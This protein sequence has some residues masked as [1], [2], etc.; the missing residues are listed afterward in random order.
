[1]SGYILG[2][3]SMGASPKICVLSGKFNSAIGEKSILIVHRGKK[4]RS[5][6]ASRVLDW[7]AAL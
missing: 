3:L 1:M 4:K 6:F 7:L 5:P 2:T